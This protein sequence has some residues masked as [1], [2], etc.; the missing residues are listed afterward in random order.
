M[1]EH[2]RRRPGRPQVYQDV[3]VVP[4]GVT[5]RPEQGPRIHA[6]A[7]ERGTSF[8]AVVRDIVGAWE[9]E[10]FPEAPRM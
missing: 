6:I 8:S 3:R 5:L 7:Q 10:T 9:R 4:Y 2:G 1:S